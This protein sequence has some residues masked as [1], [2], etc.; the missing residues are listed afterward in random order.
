MMLQAMVH[1]LKRQDE[2]GK[3]CLA[4]PAGHESELTL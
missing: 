4:W 3:Q 1:N 2:T